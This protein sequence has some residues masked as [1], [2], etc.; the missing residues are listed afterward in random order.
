M[1]IE[2][3]IASFLCIGLVLLSCKE[4]PLSEIES[5]DWNNERSVLAITF[6]NQV[7]RAEIE[8]IDESTGEI[9]IA[10]NIG[11][12]PDLSN[13]V[14]SEL[15]LSYGAES[16]LK[17]GEALSF[18]NETN[19]NSITITSPTGK[20][21]EYTITTTSFSETILGTYSID[22]LLV[23]GGTGPEF[24]GAAVIPM[25]DKPWAWLETGGPASELD[26]TVTF[27]LTGI[28]EDGNTFG[29]IVNSAGEDEEYADFMFVLD[30][31]TDVNNRYRVIPKGEGSWSRNYTTGTVTFE[32]DDIS[33]TGTFETAATEDLGNGINIT[34]ENYALAFVQSG[35]DDWDNIYSDYD[36]F[37][38]N[39]RK[40]WILL[41]K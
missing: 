23:F 25:I 17:V 20:T 40:Y 38:K 3:Y 16:S 34:I 5:G 35:E 32:F 11:A 10:I 30:P 41:S 6:E 26:N 24:G 4:N 39:P 2:K 36:K 33:A 9:E 27:T 18:E 7:G 13:I 21:R 14:L 15:E 8:R 22:D 12:V 1:K 31:Q 19:S 28:T 29:T 37:V